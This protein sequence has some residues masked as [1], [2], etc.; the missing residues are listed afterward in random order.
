MAGSQITA[1]VQIVFI[2]FIVKEINSL[3][4]FPRPKHS[5]LGPWGSRQEATW[6]HYP[7]LGKKGR[8]GRRV[9]SRRAWG[10]PLPPTELSLGAAEVPVPGALDPC[11]WLHIWPGQG[12]GACSL[13]RVGPQVVLE[14]LFVA[15]ALGAVRAGVWPLA[16]VRTLMLQ[17]VVLLREALATLGAVVGPLTRVDAP[18]FQQ[19]VL[20]DEALAALRAG[21]R[22]LA[23]VHAAVVG[24]LRFLTEALLALRALK[25]P[26]TSM[27]PLVAQQMRR[28]A[29]TL[30]AQTANEGDFVLACM[31]TLVDHQTDM[32]AEALLA[33]WARVGPLT[34]VCD[35]VLGQA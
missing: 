13:A 3:K 10:A 11:T 15:E 21:V 31:H 9:H 17:Q 6:S 23:G 8:E 19:V 2:H 30:A 12:R 24:E 1:P 27:S 33:F 29:E 26:F 14:R 25:R 22:P 7:V 18:V 5:P 16:C 32:Q 28:A 4:G 34:R 20:A 35:L